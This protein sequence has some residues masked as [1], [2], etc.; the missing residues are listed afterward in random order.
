MEVR[1]V[2]CN[3]CGNIVAFVKDSGVRPVCCSQPM[4]DLVP[5]TTDAAREKH[6][7]VLTR[8]GD[9]VTVA[10]GSVPHPMTAEHRIEWVLLQT[11][12]GNQRMALAP[13]E[14]PSAT[15]ALTPGDEPL[16]AYAYCNLHG[17]WKAE[18]PEKQ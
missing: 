18:A 15:F 7:P 10:V 13:G 4:Q 6:V 3:V 2:K 12:R 14:A 8:E 11:R 16:A 17:L 1:F 5:N 9:T